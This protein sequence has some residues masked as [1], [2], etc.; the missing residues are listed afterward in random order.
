MNHPTGPNE[1]PTRRR[2]LAAGA[3]A[4][5]VGLAGCSG[6]EAT[7]EATETP[8][9]IPSIQ[10]SGPQAAAM[11]LPARVMAESF[12]E[13]ADAA[14]EMAYQPPPAIQQAIAAE[15]VESGTFPPVA[16][17]RLFGE[18]KTGI[19][20]LTPLARSFNSIVVRQ[21]AGISGIE[22]LLDVTLGTMPRSSAPWTSWAV[23]AEEEGLDHTAFDYRFGPPAVLFGAAMQGD[24]DALIGVEPFSSRLLLTDEFEEIYVFSDRWAEITGSPLPLVEVATYQMT[25]DAKPQAVSALVEGLLEANEQISADPVGTIRRFREKLGLQEE[26]QYEFVA[27]RIGDIYP[28]SFDTALREGGREL[29]ARAVTAGV[30]DVDPAE[31]IF[32][33][34]RTL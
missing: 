23:L 5:I 4:L 10:F 15:A 27:G 20:L 21:E 26:T 8:T 30:L 18:G 22:D 13:S 6:Q 9:S 33:D 25:I 1:Q 24:L 12:S 16:G 2:L 34:P 29:I 7:P 32:V 19:R 14:I 11:T 31:S 3:G 17:A 28:G